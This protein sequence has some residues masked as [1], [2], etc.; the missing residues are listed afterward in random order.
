MHIAANG[1]V[2]SSVGGATSFTNTLSTSFDG[3][4]E[5]I[6][7]GDSDD[8]SFGNGTTDL[9]FSVSFWLKLN[10]SIDSQVYISKNRGGPRR[11]WTIGSFST[12]KI[13]IALN[14]Q[15]GNS[16]QS[17]D[18]TTS[19][20]DNQWY[21]VICT[22]SGVG[23]SSAYQGLKI[24]INGVLETPTNI[25]SGTYTAMSNTVAPLTIGRYMAGNVY[26]NGLIDEPAIFDTELNQTQITS[27]SA[28]PSDLTTYAPVAWWR[29]D[30]STSPTLT[31]LGSGGNNGSMLNMD[32]ANFVADVP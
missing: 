17:I 30:V 27:I 19:L 20:N 25:V 6:T 29:A 31:D 24:Y 8:F 14:N 5:F 1:I 11:E 4:D 18:S 10:S 12:N 26:T 28:T 22:Y 23:G 7:C 13:Q 32:A 21:S 2:A 16:E 15:G 9:P 3:V